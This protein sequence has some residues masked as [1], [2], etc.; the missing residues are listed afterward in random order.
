[1]TTDVMSLQTLV[2]DQGMQPVKIVH[3][4]RALVLLAGGKIEILDSYENVIRG[5]SLVM[6]VP[7]VVRLKRGF[8]RFKKPVKFS[9][10]NVYARDD[11]R[12]QYCNQR[13]RIEDLTYDHVVPRAQG[14]K[15]TWTNITTACLECN[16][17]KA[18]RTPEQAGM[19]LLKKPVQPVDNPRSAIPIHPRSM[20]QAWKDYVYWT[21]KLDQD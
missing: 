14:G 3:W 4:Q 17:R 20:P 15:T 7:A 8:K 6:N 21:E 11:Y 13:R 10:I 2:L 1:M 12:C 5:P 9:R 16:G 19:K 18:N